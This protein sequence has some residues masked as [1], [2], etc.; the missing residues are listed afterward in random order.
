LV[1]S[2]EVAMGLGRPWAISDGNAGAL[3][4]TFSNDPLALD[5][6]DWSAIGATFWHG[7][8]HQKQ[9]EFLV[10]DFFPW[11]GILAIGCHNETTAG[12]VRAELGSDGLR[13]K[14]IVKPNWYY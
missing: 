11:E 3:H 12:Q 7:M 9:A 10:G 6:L 2:V 13:P 4:A 5:D 1:S 8:Q 14:V